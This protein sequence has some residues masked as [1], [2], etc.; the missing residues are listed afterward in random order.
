M[1]C[2]YFKNQINVSQK[3]TNQF[4]F[5]RYI[6]YITEQTIFSCFPVVEK[7]KQKMASEQDSQPE[8]KRSEH[9]ILY[10]PSEWSKR[11]GPD[12]VNMFSIF[13]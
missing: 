4:K 2:L 12:E 6:D 13:T 10:S 1:L 3:H 8:S 9:E 5:C 11:F 7:R